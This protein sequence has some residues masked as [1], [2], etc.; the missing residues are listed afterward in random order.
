MVST[1]LFPKGLT[2]AALIALGG[3]GLAQVPVAPPSAADIFEEVLHEHG[4]EAAAARLR[5]MMGSACLRLRRG[6]SATAGTRSRERKSM[7]RA[8]ASR[9]TRRGAR[10]RGSASS[11]SATESTTALHAWKGS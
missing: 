7:P 11:C 1:C 5:T 10:D 8:P 2:A 3:P 4:I 9:G 6:E